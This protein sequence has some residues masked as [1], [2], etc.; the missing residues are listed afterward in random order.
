MR[1]AEV[2]V[3]VR[4]DGVGVRSGVKVAWGGGAVEGDTAGV[5]GVQGKGAVVR[6]RVSLVGW[7]WE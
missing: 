4:V 5:R 3:S 6:R 2:G 1:V 7:V